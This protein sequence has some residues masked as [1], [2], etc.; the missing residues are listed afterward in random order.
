MVEVRVAGGV[1]RVCGGGGEEGCVVS[2][3]FSLCGVCVCV[4]VWSGVGCGGAGDNVDTDAHGEVEE[5][6]EA[7]GEEHE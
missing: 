4:C 7:A 2:L 3:S 6:D 5:S 1:V